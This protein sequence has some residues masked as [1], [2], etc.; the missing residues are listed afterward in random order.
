SPTEGRIYHVT[1]IAVY[2]EDTATTFLLMGV[3]VGASFYGFYEED[4][5]HGIGRLWHTRCDI[6]LRHGDTIRASL[7]GGVSGDTCYITLLGNHM[8]EEI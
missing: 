5:A 1:H 8:T 7:V 6:Y 3:Q 2:D 4:A